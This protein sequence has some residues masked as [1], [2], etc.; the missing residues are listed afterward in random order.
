MAAWLDVGHDAVPNRLV[1]HQQD[2]LGRAPLGVAAPASGLVALPEHL[3]E[4]QA[5]QGPPSRLIIGPDRL[6]NMKSDRRDAS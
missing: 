1:P 5:E 6:N 2:L 3:P 4:L